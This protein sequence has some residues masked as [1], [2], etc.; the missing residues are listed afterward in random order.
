MDD[1]K[2][3]LTA[4]NEAMA[5]GDVEGFLRFCDDEIEWEMVGDVTLSGKSA[6]REHLTAGPDPT[7]FTVTDLIAEGEV[8]VA[9][10]EIVATDEAGRRVPSAYCDV[11][12]F[13]DGLM[14]ALRAFV[15]PTGR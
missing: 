5:R 7:T 8:L 2:Q 15:I 12:T 9:T 14:S 13:R 6:V 11:W 4:A 1:P 10:G 3:I